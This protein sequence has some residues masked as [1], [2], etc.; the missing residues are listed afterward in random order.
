VINSQ[1]TFLRL[2]LDNPNLKKLN[3]EIRKRF[4]V[5]KATGRVGN[6]RVLFTGYFEPVFDGSLKPDETYKYPIYRQPDDL[7]KIDLSLFREEFEGKT[8]VARIKDK[9]VLP[10]YSR[11]QIEGEKVLEGK[12]L[13][14][15]WLK[16]PLDVTFLHIQGSGRIRLPGGETISVG[17]QASNGLPYQS[18]GRYMLEKQ[19]LSREEMSMQGIRD[20]LSKHPEI[21]GD[22][23]N[24]NQSYIFFRVLDNGP[25]GNLAV[26]LTPGRSL[27]LDSS[28]FPKGAL[29]FISSKK[30]VVDSNN[31]ITGWR[32]FSRFVLNQ[33]TGGAVKG[34]GRGDIFWGS[35]P[36]AE[37][38]AG[39]LQDEG[40]LF[41]LIEK[42]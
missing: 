8:I 27:A 34:A 11:A 35:G 15:A 33:D 21:M 30:P 16:D 19:L 14:I 29:C 24:Q 13:E 5:Y 40:E 28:L 32:N 37:V 36:Y 9:E 12:G 31:K 22:V 20:Y 4:L 17:Y 38:A 6:R 7:I 3:E 1:K 26:P 41:V 42:P 18:I 25:L 23:L 10:Y 2:I 39:N